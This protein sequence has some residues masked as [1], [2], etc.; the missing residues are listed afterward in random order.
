MEKSFRRGTLERGSAAPVEGERFADIAVLT[1]AR[2]EQI[3]S[4]RL[5]E[6]VSFEQAHDEWVVV[7]EGGARMLVDGEEVTLGCGDWLLLPA[8]CPHTVLATQPGTA[9]LA[10]H[11]R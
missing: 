6:P 3:L 5:S 1:G 11:S 10:V 8:G 7:V 2:V 4:G 9:W